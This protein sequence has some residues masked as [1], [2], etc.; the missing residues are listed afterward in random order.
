MDSLQD[1]VETLKNDTNRVNSLN[2]L[3][4]SH[5]IN[6]PDSAIQLTLLSERLALEL[7]FSRGLAESKSNRSV[8]YTSIGDYSISLQLLLESNL[9]YEQ[10]GD[11][12]GV[13][14]NANRIGRIYSFTKEY[15][16][17]IEYYEQSAQ[18][19]KSVGNKREEGKAL[20][21]IGY[22]HK[23][24]SNYDSALTYLHKAY[25]INEGFS[26][27]CQMLYPIYNIGSVYVKLNLF[28]SA[29][30]FLNESYRLATQCSDNYIQSLSLIDLG[31]LHV[32]KNELRLAIESYL[33][34]IDVSKQVG[35]KSEMSTAAYALANVYESLNEH[36]KALNYFKIYQATNDSL[37]NEANTKQITMLE[38]QYQFNRKQQQDETERLAKEFEQKRELSREIWIR[39]SF[40]VG[41]VL[42]L[43]ISY[44]LYRNFDRKRKANLLLEQLFQEIN[45]QQE[46]LIQQAANLKNAND[47]ISNI[48]SNLEEI[49]KK[50]TIELREQNSKLVKYVFYNSHKVR[51]PLARILG[52]ASLFNKDAL[53]PSEI[54]E[55]LSRIYKEAISL[56]E[57]VKEMNRTLEAESK[58]EE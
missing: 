16:K 25:R 17:A 38:A 20:N 34:A 58:V 32:A 45:E 22:L 7:S 1:R 57:L 14:M 23:I 10:I 2:E 43:I 19:F 52:I 5:R 44:L 47:E 27:S 21:N 37:F 35:L 11:M 26:D 12:E 39:N 4:Y 41:F 31:D 29:S 40:V 13:A 42:M 54:S 53:S 55:M 50:R 6:D 56:D 46:E 8:A 28:D 30:N 36:S 49:V 33:N 9:I 24:T 18:L 48:N 15:D 51:A 3:A